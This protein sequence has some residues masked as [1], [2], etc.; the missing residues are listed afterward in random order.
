[1]KDFAEREAK[2]E[3]GE[4][5][6]EDCEEI[7]QYGEEGAGVQSFL[8]SDWGRSPIASGRGWRDCIEVRNGRMRI[9]FCVRKMPFRLALAR[10]FGGGGLAT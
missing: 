10:N 8:A 4:G 5:T 3:S 1:M 7:R 9:C 2:S 6:G